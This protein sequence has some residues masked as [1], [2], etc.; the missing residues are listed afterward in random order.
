[1]LHIL[2]NSTSGVGRLGNIL[3]PKELL[4]LLLL[5]I[6]GDKTTDRDCCLSRS[7]S[8]FKLLPCHLF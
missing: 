1:M 7:G 6:W 5:E 3:P 2:R 4:K 8:D